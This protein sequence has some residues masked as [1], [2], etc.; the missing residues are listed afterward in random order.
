MTEALC[1]EFDLV[2]IGN[3]RRYSSY[4][5]AEN[6]VLATE[7]AINKNTKKLRRKRKFI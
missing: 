3:Y 5:V 2:S 7:L 6:S 1:T 4:K